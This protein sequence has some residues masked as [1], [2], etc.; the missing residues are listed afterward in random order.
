MQYM[1]IFKG[2]LG[3]ELKFE[4]WHYFSDLGDLYNYVA[5]Q[6]KFVG[7]KNLYDRYD[8]RVKNPKVD[9]MPLAA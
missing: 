4:E 8:I 1:L 3:D 6:L 7:G 2:Y 5:A 9:N